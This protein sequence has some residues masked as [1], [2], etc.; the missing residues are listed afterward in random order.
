ME[1]L[2]GNKGPGAKTMTLL[3]AQSPSTPRSGAKSALDLVPPTRNPKRLG[4][5]CTQGHKRRVTGELPWVPWPHRG[6]CHPLGARH[7]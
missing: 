7:L 5:I 2:R 3:T 4:T 1:D 6:A